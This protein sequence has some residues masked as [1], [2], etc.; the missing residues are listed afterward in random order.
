MCRCLGPPWASVARDQ[1]SLVQTSQ[2]IASCIQVCKTCD[3]SVTL[4]FEAPPLPRSTIE[5]P[6]KPTTNPFPLR[7]V[8]GFL[9][10][11][12]PPPHL[13]GVGWDSK[14]YPL[15]L[16]QSGCKKGAGRCSEEENEEISRPQGGGVRSRRT[17]QPTIQ[18]P[19]PLPQGVLE[20]PPPTTTT[21]GGVVGFSRE[22]PSPREGVGG[23]RG[24]RGGDSK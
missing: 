12:Q 1:L 13:Q 15:P 8:G 11:P 22:N 20:N 24:T 14:V 10:N 6:C 7:G 21:S 19:T 5:A 16:D 23:N 17:L 2:E 18:S 9:E 3:T 4:I